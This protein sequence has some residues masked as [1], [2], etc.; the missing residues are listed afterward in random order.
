[1]S[2]SS[3]N[4][5]VLKDKIKDLCKLSN[6]RVLV[7]NYHKPYFSIF[8]ENFELIKNYENIEDIPDDLKTI[9]YLSISSDQ[10]DKIFLTTTNSVIQ[11]DFKFKSFKMLKDEIRFKYLSNCSYSAKNGYLY[12][13]D[14]LNK[15]IHILDRNLES[16]DT[17]ILFYQPLKIEILNETICVMPQYDCREINC[18]HFY[19]LNTFNFIFILNFDHYGPMG[20]FGSSFFSFYDYEN[21]KL[22]LIQQNGYFNDFI[23]IKIDKNKFHLCDKIF[24]LNGNFYITSSINEKIFFLPNILT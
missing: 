10:I 16:K 15:T 21:S 13:C 22:H 18:L 20:T 3:S 24:D 6:N 12:I 8:D 4:K 19:D 5:K 14:C 1:M 23:L 7:S 2:E 11:T 9:N 17:Y